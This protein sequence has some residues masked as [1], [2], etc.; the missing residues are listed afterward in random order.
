MFSYELV[1]H[2]AWVVSIS[3]CCPVGEKLRDV[4]MVESKNSSNVNLGFIGND[5]HEI[6]CKMN[7][8]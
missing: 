2:D 6:S 1:F 5:E 3:K 7:R 4:N 8:A